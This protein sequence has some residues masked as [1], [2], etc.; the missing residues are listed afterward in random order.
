MFLQPKKNNRVRVVE[1]NVVVNEIDS[2]DHNVLFSARRKGI[3]TVGATLRQVM[4]QLNLLESA[5]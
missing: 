1:G 3:I 4:E 5:K 2:D